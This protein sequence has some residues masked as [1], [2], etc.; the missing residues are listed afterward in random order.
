MNPYESPSTPATAKGDAPP[1]AK[2]WRILLF[3]L[4]AMVPWPLLALGLCF[5]GDLF[6]KAFE[7]MFLFGSITMLLL[8]P[9]M[10]AGFEIPDAVYGSIVGVVWSAALILP[11]FAPIRVRQSHVAVI[12]MIV[13]QGLFS[14]AQAALGVLMIVGKNV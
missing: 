11:T 10:C 9:L 7:A 6:D 5:W 1:R 4:A 14:F 3:S 2:R 12:I 8:L 13:L